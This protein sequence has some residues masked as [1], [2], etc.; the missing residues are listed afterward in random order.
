VDLHITEALP[1]SLR[2]YVVA[3]ESENERMKMVAV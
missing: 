1:N 2:G 3:V